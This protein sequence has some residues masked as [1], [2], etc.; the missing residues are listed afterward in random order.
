MQLV[1]KSSS[2]DTDAKKNDYL[3][4]I[5]AL[6]GAMLGILQLFI[7]ANF[8]IL[9]PLGIAILVIAWYRPM[10]GLLILLFI[11]LLKVPVDGISISVVEIGLGKIIGFV[12]LASII[13]KKI[14][15]GD[16]SFVWSREASLLTIFIAIGFVSAFFSKN[17]TVS[18]YYSVSMI[19]AILI[20]FI[21]LINILSS[22][23][24]IKAVVWMIV[25]LAISVTIS[26]YV[27]DFFNL[28]SRHTESDR[29]GGLWTAYSATSERGGY[30]RQDTIWDP[31]FF[32]VTLA[33]TLPLIAYII[34]QTKS[35]L[36]KV[37]LGITTI[38]FIFTILMTASRV[39]FLTLCMILILFVLFF[40]KYLKVWA[41]LVAILFGLIMAAPDV[42][43]RRLSALSTI[44]EGASSSIDTVALRFK[45]I[46]VSL[47]LFLKSPLLGVGPGNFFIESS[48]YVTF[49][50]SSVYAH[51]TYLTIL[52]EMGIVAL[53]LYLLFCY[54]VLSNFIAARR[55]SKAGGSLHTLSTFLLISYIGLLL[56]DLALGMFFW[57]LLGI[58]FAGLSFTLKRIAMYGDNPKS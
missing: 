4:V 54:C 48:R 7:S 21:L 20:S 49:L 44:A 12:V 57:S 33:I 46:A 16:R 43:F 3:L 5:I 13:T 56:T 42:F 31:N 2:Q 15:N 29:F 25:L 9:L 26:Q 35:R 24:H 47:D 11:K 1:K 14:L 27:L 28:Q 40:R 18:F 45:L 58:V 39:A 51:N 32:G 53:A 8:L 17:S 41:T 10:F 30:T 55:Y 34:S 37:L 50:G 19:S 23:K 52:A 38:V 6:G 36:I 22:E